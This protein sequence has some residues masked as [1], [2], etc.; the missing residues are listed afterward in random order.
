MNVQEIEKMLKDL[1][2][3]LNEKKKQ[4]EE[5]NENSENNEME[6]EVQEKEQEIQSNENNEIE[7]EEYTLGV[8]D[9]DPSTA[10]VTPKSKNKQDENENENY[11][12]RQYLGVE[13]GL[14][15]IQWNDLSIT[16]EPIENI[17]SD[18][19]EKR[20]F[21]NSCEPWITSIV[22]HNKKI[23]DGQKAIIYCRQSSD[24]EFNE[25]QGFTSVQDQIDQCLEFCYQNDLKV[26]DVL[27]EKNKSARQGKN[28][29]TRAWKAFI[30]EN[31]DVEFLV[32]AKPC[33][34]SRHVES[35]EKQIEDLNMTV[36]SAL[37][38]NEF[39]ERIKEA[40]NYSDE[41][42]RIS[43]SAHKNFKIQQQQDIIDEIN[44][45]YEI[46]V[47]TDDKDIY[48]FNVIKLETN[49]LGE[50][51]ILCKYPN[52]E[53]K[54]LFTYPNENISQVRTNSGEEFIVPLNQKNK[55]TRQE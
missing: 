40:E 13:N 16:L 4:L 42:S 46:E 44:E 11:Y 53:T 1:E 8:P 47:K 19:N 25:N 15:K 3:Q 32:V 18:E 33:R 34:F 10:K 50:H 36:V 17:G 28:F 37:Y 14:V 51:F 2:I 6:I 7:Q 9:L 41:Q 5:E 35:A 27:Y 55:K 24:V 48:N 49:I 20:K 22:K 21:N 31:D 43:T 52:S 23:E 26:M 54:E 39:I 38:G 29:K 45:T 12:V 30:K